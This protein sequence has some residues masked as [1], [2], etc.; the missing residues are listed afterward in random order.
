MGVQSK[1]ILFF[2]HQLINTCVEAA[3]Y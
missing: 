2:I 3:V 1:I